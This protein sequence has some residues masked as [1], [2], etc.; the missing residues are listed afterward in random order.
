MSDREVDQIELEAEKSETVGSR[1]VMS[2]ISGSAAS[3]LPASTDGATLADS[4]GQTASGAP[5]TTH[6]AAIPDSDANG[7]SSG[8]VTSSEEDVNKTFS[9]TQTASSET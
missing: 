4:A 5:Q 6:D 9:S 2:L 1:E 3:V 7:S 8:E